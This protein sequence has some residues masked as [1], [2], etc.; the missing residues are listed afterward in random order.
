M[1]QLPENVTALL[2]HQNIWYL[3][4]YSDIPL[5]LIHISSSPPSPTR[6]GRT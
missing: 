2:S 5:S 4:T 6:T 1:K 3:G